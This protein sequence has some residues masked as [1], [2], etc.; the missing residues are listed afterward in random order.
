[1]NT[2]KLD[3]LIKRLQKIRDKKG[4][5]PAYYKTNKRNYHWLRKVYVEKG[6]GEKNEEKDVVIFTDGEKY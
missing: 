5:I 4:N 6:S 2:I 1:M 3:S